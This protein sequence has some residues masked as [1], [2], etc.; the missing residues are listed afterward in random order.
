MFRRKTPEV[1]EDTSSS[2]SEEEE[3]EAQV[4]LLH[5]RRLTQTNS[6]SN[7]CSALGKVVLTEETCDTPE[8]FQQTLCLLA[9]G[10]ADGAIRLY[11]SNR[12]FETLWIRSSSNKEAAIV[13]ISWDAT[14]TVLGAIDAAGL[15]AIWELKYKVATVEATGNAL[16]SFVAAAFA[17]STTTTTQ[18]PVLQLAGTP[19][20]HRLSYPAAYSTP[21]CLVLD[22]KRRWLVGFADGRVVLTKRG[23]VFQRRSDVVLH[24]GS[25]VLSMAW[26]GSWIA[27][28]DATGIRVMET[29]TWTKVAH[30]ERPKGALASTRPSLVWEHCDQLLV[31]W[32]DCLMALKVLQDATERRRKVECTMAWELDCVALG[33]APLDRTHALVLGLMGHE[34]PYEVELQ[35]VSRE[36]GQILQSDLVPLVDPPT[37]KRNRLRLG[38]KKESGPS[39][40][41]LLSSFAVPRMDTV[42]ESADDEGRG[43]DPLQSALFPSAAASPKSSVDPQDVWDLSHVDFGS[44]APRKELTPF[45]TDDSSVDSDDYD[46]YR[47]LSNEAPTEQTLAVSPVLYL[48]SSND[49]V[50]SRVR[51]IDDAIAQAK[52]LALHATALRL[53][54]AH[55]RKLRKYKLEDLVNDYMSALLRPQHDA[56]A[57]PLSLRRMK[58]AAE[59]MPMLIGG[60]TEQ[61]NRWVDELES[62][63]GALFVVRSHLPVRGT[64]RDAGRS[65]C[66]LLS[67]TAVFR[68]YT[69]K[70]SV[71]ESSLCHVRAIA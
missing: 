31:A 33:V 48:V 5:Y 30:V 44:I 14:G 27:W 53:G 36:T 50:L 18:P 66:F 49:L 19:Q 37:P 62:M 65:R 16:T 70:G 67:L 38:G 51:S 69:S 12:L 28:A 64:S 47:E 61:W 26:R 59:A 23:F 9:V 60:N 58:L 20:V 32:G 71:S 8:W 1:V 63:P 25:S 68:S 4:P 52:S 24:Q 15:C 13:G 54:L 22:T 41:T 57:R 7:C 46:F 40:F 3:E 55:I 45:E 42:A 43:M 39:Y 34:P 2:S 21:T 29:E 6:S 56:E 35:V 11:E 10:S 17:P